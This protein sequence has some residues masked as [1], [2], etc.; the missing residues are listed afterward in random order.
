[1][2]ERDTEQ[3]VVQLE[4]RIRDFERNF[5]KANR[6]ATKNWSDI[7]SRG[8]RAARNLE[9][10][11]TR[12]GGSLKGIAGSFAGAFAG[13]FA[14]GGLA[15][16]PQLIRSTVASAAGIADV[17]DKIGLTT[18]RLQE[19]RFAADQS[20]IEASELDGAM[21][22]FSRRVG[23]AA[24]GGGDL[25]K[26]LQANGIALRNA[27]GTL[28]P[29]NDLLADFADLIQ[30]AGSDQDRLALAVDAFGRSG[31][32]MVNLLREGSAGLNQLTADARDAG[33]VLGD[34][35]VRAAADVDDKFAVLQARFTTFMQSSIIEFV[36][37][38]REVMDDLA[39]A[40]DTAANAWANFEAVYNRVFRITPED[41][42]RGKLRAALVRGGVTGN[43]G[44]DA[45][46]SD[47]VSFGQ[48]PKG[49]APGTATK[50][51]VIP[52]ARTGGGSRSSAA[53]DVD[54][55]RKAVEELIASLEQERS[56]IGASATETRLATEL[57]RAGAS[58]T[59]AQKA[60]IRALI[61]EIERE[62]AANDRLAAG[63]DLVRS[64]AQDTFSGI[65]QNL[66]SGLAPMEA[67][68]NAIDSLTDRLLE[69]A[70]NWIFNALLGAPGTSGSGIVGKLLGFSDGGLV[71][72]PGSSR[73][74]SIPARLSDG[75]FVVN[76]AATRQ[77]LALLQALNAG[78]LPT[79]R[80]GGIVGAVPN[81]SGRTAGPTMITIAPNVTVQASGGSQEANAD[82]AKQT[83]REV[84]A[85]MRVL[86]A[87]ELIAQMRP[88]G[89]FNR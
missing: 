3:L 77:H 34:D 72:G 67:L 60:K 8:N 66:R 89:L 55:Q 79:F 62:K 78:K 70:E 13:G 45:D 28:R 9:T 12:L 17:A 18:E 31:D 48:A 7:E 27:D 71:R 56:L 39:G 6:T 21:A 68:G 2:A 73:S 26:I 10:T 51:T 16:L 19:L 33:A 5:E 14:I 11:F 49:D 81:V 63:I 74:D 50:P 61:P 75:E 84:E 85:T 83:A 1:M 53:S 86:V 64:T 80:D 76:A 65:R 24:A 32:G 44:Q 29:I 25:L 54:R 42:A 58:A 47:W 88:G 82:L 20:G 37:D 35:L 22:Q 40:A 57:R 59:D 30:N 69:L 23:E 41:A 36:G 43:L 15:Q 38:V 46:F 87:R 52:P 4:A